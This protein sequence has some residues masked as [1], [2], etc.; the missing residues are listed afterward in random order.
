MS[1]VSVISKIPLFSGCSEEVLKKVAS[2]LKRVIYPSGNFVFKKGD[3]A[4]RM[5]LIFT[6]KVAVQSGDGVVF[7]RLAEGSFFGEMGLLYSAPRMASVKTESESE[8]FELSKDEFE[9]LKKT[10]PEIIDRVKQI[11]DARFEWFKKHLREELSGDKSVA[12]F[13]EEQVNNFR[14]VFHDV[15]LDGSG[16]IDTDELGKLLFKLNGREFNRT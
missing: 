1:E 4:N 6:G 15:D 5:Y 2:R 10:S 11:A 7:A 3:L 16:A 14:Q 12:D 13:T 9:S 8:F